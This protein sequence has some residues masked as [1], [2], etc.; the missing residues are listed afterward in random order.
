MKKHSFIAL[1]IFMV[2]TMFQANAQAP[3]KHG[4]GATVGSMQAFSYKTF[5]TDHFAIQLDLGTKYNYSIIA[6][7]GS[8]L[9]TTELAASFM[10]EGHFVKGLVA[11]ERIG[12]KRC[13]HCYSSNLGNADVFNA[14]NTCNCRIARFLKRTR[15]SDCCLPCSISIAL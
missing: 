11:T 15:R 4:I 5:P 7:Y 13:V 10:Y 2:A 8:T 3:Y 14:D 9:W 12:S 6:G 1:L